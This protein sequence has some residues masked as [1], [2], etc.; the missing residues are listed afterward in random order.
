[1]EAI[2]ARCLTGKRQLVTLFSGFALLALLLG[3][4]GVYGVTAFMVGRRTRETAIRMALGADARSVVLDSL[5]RL[6]WP[7]GLGLAA[8][9]LGAW[10]LS[11]L[12][13]S[14]LV[15]VEATDPGLFLTVALVLTLTVAAA[16]YRRPAAPR[17]STRRRC[18]VRSRAPAPHDAGACRRRVTVRSP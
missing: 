12:L 13:E 2:A 17:A 10:S 3:A 18:S 16:G 5:G 9:L 14:A 4:V 7:A 15:E 6:A 11:H 8:G 1:M